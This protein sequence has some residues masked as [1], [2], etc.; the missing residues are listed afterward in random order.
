MLLKSGVP[1]FKLDLNTDLL[2]LTVLW[3]ECLTAAITK[4]GYRKV[5]FVYHH[6]K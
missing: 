3:N 6:K 4:K 5:L 1:Y 2:V